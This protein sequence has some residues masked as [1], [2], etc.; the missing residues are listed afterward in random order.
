[1]T[2]QTAHKTNRASV[3]ER[4]IT[5]T[6]WR[7]VGTMLPA[8]GVGNYV[9][10]K[11]KNTIPSG[12]ILVASITPDPSM[13]DKWPVEFKLR[14]N[15]TGKYGETEGSA[16][17][18]CMTY[19]K[20]IA[21]D[22]YTLIMKQNNKDLNRYG[23]I[24]EVVDAMEPFQPC[25]A[26]VHY[27]E[28]SPGERIQDLTYMISNNPEHLNSSVACRADIDKKFLCRGEIRGRARVY[29]EHLNEYGKEMK[30]G[31][32]LWNSSGTDVYVTLQSRSFESGSQ[33]S[34][35]RPNFMDAVVDVWDNVFAGTLN[36]GEEEDESGTGYGT[37]KVAAGSSRWIALSRVPKGNKENSMLFNGVVTMTLR[38]GD[39]ESSA[40]FTGEGVYCDTYIM[41]LETDKSFV[42]NHV[43]EMT[44]VQGVGEDQIRGSGTGAVLYANVTKQISISDSEPFRFLITGKQVPE[45]QTG[46]EIAI[47][48][49]TGD[50]DEPVKM[51]NCQNYAVLYRITFSRGFSLNNTTRKLKAK[52]VYNRRTNPAATEYPDSGIHIAGFWNEGENVFKANLLVKEEAVIATDIPI[53]KTVTLNIV[54]SG[55]SVMPPEIDFYTL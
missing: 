40:L 28:G 55:M 36:D 19:F 54:V 5:L 24:I 23:L 10:F 44:L 15:T 6:R 27:S 13:K 43:R 22:T 32:L 16:S 20:T 8:P 52:V 49:L 31:V 39:K 17:G 35:Q 3:E 25:D 51:K 26:G 45:I 1:M 38:T 18:N 21:E 30:F 4:N 7:Y 2:T 14:G 37:F 42:Q 48:T 12:K 33:G 29:Y 50:T 41:N 53:G 34:T 46:E 9:N 11:I 47:S